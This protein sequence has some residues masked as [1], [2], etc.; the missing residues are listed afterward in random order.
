MIKLSLPRDQYWIDLHPM[1]RVKVRPCTT[2][3]VEA[4]RTM[5][6][7]V[8]GDIIN[9]SDDLLMVEHDV[10][11]LQKRLSDP[12]WC[13]GVR[14][15]VYV[16]CLAKLAIVEWSG[17]GVETKAGEIGPINT[18]NLRDVLLHSD[19]KDVFINEYTRPL[20]Q[21]ISEGNA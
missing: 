4:A 10:A 11:D 5:A 9:G 17:P 14:Q 21:V 8:M 6:A 7:R 2:P 16:Q 3:I 15:F 1:V 13:A 12:D 18:E 19:I 20:V